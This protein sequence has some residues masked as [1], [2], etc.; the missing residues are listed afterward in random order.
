MRPTRT[1]A[2]FGALVLAFPLP[3]TP[4]RAYRTPGPQHP[5]PASQGVPEDVWPDD[6]LE[7]CL[8]KAENAP[9][10][11]AIYLDMLVAC[12]SRA[13]AAWDR[14]L[15]KEWS[16]VRKW[17]PPE[18]WPLLREAQRRWLAWRDAEFAWLDARFDQRLTGFL[19]VAE[20]YEKR[21]EFVEARAIHIGA[22]STHQQ[23]PDALITGKH[24]P[25]PSEEAKLA[26]QLEQVRQALRTYI[27]RLDQAYVYWIIE[28]GGREDI[29]RPPRRQK[30]P[31][32][33]HLFRGAERRWEAF[34]EAEFAW[35]DALYARRENVRRHERIKLL[36]E[37][38]RQ[39][40]DFLGGLKI[41][42]G[43]RQP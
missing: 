41:H 15:N 18:V 24:P 12:Y 40:E 26:R 37:R 5:T 30:E 20:L 6:W 22:L 33:S 4:L 19:G 2:V 39:L 32:P 43:E 28:G 29:P 17:C 13:E 14:Y 11:P 42:F 25:D 8:E 16:E 7:D 38:L 27:R 31:L 10:G 3:G 1:L 21:K 23:L 9:T 36:R 35:L 34:R